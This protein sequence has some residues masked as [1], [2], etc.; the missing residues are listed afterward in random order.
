[1]GE[2][3]QK[4]R[5]ES[6]EW[7]QL[8]EPPSPARLAISRPEARLASERKYGQSLA[9]WAT[10]LPHDDILCFNFH[11]DNKLRALPDVYMFLLPEKDVAPLVLGVCNACAQHSNAELLALVRDQFGKYY[12]LDQQSP[13]NSARVELEFPPGIWFTIAGVSFAMPG[14]ETPSVPGGPNV[15]V[16]SMNR[17]Y[18]RNQHWP[19]GCHPRA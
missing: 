12:G 9:A 6:R 1:M 7:V 15:F 19:L 17:A 18:S 11:C 2:A 3:R 14:R 8:F 10:E 4:A 13:A 16:D 5:Q